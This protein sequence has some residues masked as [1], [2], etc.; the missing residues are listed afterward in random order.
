MRIRQYLEDPSLRAQHVCTGCKFCCKNHMNSNEPAD[1]VP[2]CECSLPIACP[3][4]NDILF[5]KGKSA[6]PH[7]GNIHFRN[8]IQT[9]YE[10]GQ[11]IYS[12]DV[13]AL[14]ETRG[15]IEALVDHFFD[16]VEKGDFRVLMWNEKFSWWSVLV[17]ENMV[18]KKI[19]NT[20]VS[21]VESESLPRTEIPMQNTEIDSNNCF[22]RYDSEQPP[23]L[24]QEDG[25][26]RRKLA[27]DSQFSSTSSWRF[28]NHDDNCSSVKGCFG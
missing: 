7:P 16:K 18:R 22:N 3:R 24:A 20:V 12:P 25:S 2:V 6:K 4:L 19:E 13:A 11:Y 1:I 26:K 8:Q 9:T 21:V 15:K 17:N 28:R 23:W 27:S 10:L 5:K 14:D